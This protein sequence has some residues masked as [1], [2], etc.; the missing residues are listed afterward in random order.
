[1][2]SIMLLSVILLAGFIPAITGQSKFNDRITVGSIRLVQRPQNNKK[3]TAIEIELRS[4]DGF[5]VGGLYYCLSIGRLVGIPE[6][7]MDPS[8]KTRLFY[9]SEAE[10]KK[11][12][13]GDVMFLSW[14]CGPR[15]IIT[16]EASEKAKREGFAFLNKRMLK[17]SKKN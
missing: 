14:G 11:L 4:A 7:G 10:W 6:E 15:E 1:M 3:Q 12:R 8:N 16:A 5:Y 2:K 9:V 13:N 17:R